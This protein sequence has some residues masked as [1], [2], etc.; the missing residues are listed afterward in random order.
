MYAKAIPAV[1]VVAAL[2]LSAEALAQSKYTDWG[3]PE[4]LGCGIN[5]PS[6]DSGMAISKDGRS[7]YFSSTRPNPRNNAA[8]IYVAHRPSRTAPWEAPVSL[9]EKIGGGS[10]PTFSRDGHWMF[11]NSARTGGFGDSDIWASYRKDVHDDFGWQPPFNLGSGVNSSGFE[12]GPSYFANE[13]GLTPQIFFG[14]GASGPAQATTTD[15]WVIGDFQNA[16][17]ASKLN[18]DE[19][20]NPQHGNQ[21]PSVRFDGLEIFFYSRRP[22]SLLGAD[23]NPSFDIWV[24]TRTHVEDEWDVPV[25]LHAQN[26]ASADVNTE[27][28]EIHPHISPDGLT[29]YFA[30][31]RPSSDACSGGLDIYVTT[32]ERLARDDDDPDDD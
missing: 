18:Q 31:S 26:S 19:D 15:I 11:F 24:A 16:R 1:L 25:N 7:L 30:S 2:W 3:R 17:P 13:H 28:S 6:N 27:A 10:N 12:A 22:G 14:R 21:R 20:G 8:E 4:R 23:G 9:G 29:L 32:R 5:S